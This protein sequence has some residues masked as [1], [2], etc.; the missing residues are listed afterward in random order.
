MSRIKEGLLFKTDADRLAWFESLSEEEQAAVRE[1]AQ[2]LAEEIVKAWQPIMEAWLSAWQQIQPI[3]MELAASYALIQAN[4]DD[5]PLVNCRV[6]GLPEDEHDTPGIRH[7][8]IPEKGK[9]EL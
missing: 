6:C 7:E 1:D 4:S 3:I 5:P 2:K 8:F 9:Y